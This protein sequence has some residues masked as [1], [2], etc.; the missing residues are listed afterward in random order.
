MKKEEIF[1]KYQNIPIDKTNLNKDIF[2][3][4][5]VNE[6]DLKHFL[7]NIYGPKDQSLTKAGLDFCFYWDLC[8]YKS[9]QSCP[10]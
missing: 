9:S 1:Q 7:Y 5:I 6:D 8:G 2:A 4:R 3:D 10:I